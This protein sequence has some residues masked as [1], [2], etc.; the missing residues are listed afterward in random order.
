MSETA[1]EIETS[2]GVA[3]PNERMVM[4]RK[5]A[6]LSQKDLA[7]KSGLTRGAI[8]LLES[9]QRNPQLMTA[10]AICDAL[11]ISVYEL[12]GRI[13]Y[14]HNEMTVRIELTKAQQKLAQIKQL[15]T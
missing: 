10:I 8:S 13:E 7:E 12:I 9:G 15:A 14:T 6:G 3:I 4:L 5:R 2:S 1:T 11:N